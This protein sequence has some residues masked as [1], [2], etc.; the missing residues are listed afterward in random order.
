MRGALVFPPTSGEA[1]VL[2]D[3]VLDGDTVRCCWLV[4]ETFRIVGINAPE[5]HGAS[6]DRG[7][8]AKAALARL[9]PAGSLARAVLHGREKYGRVLADLYGA[10][11]SVAQAL[12]AGGLALPWDGTGA[13][14]GAAASHPL[15]KEGE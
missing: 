7:L 5:T 4:G 11:G 1:A 8:A 2:I 10:G 3:E 12:L 6:R 14:P 9:L 13:R 15:V